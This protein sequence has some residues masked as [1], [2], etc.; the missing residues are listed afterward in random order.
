MRVYKYLFTLLS[1]VVV[2]ACADDKSDSAMSVES[3]TIEID[4]VGG[5]K[6]LKVDIADNWIVSTDNA[7]ITVSPANGA[8]AALRSKAKRNGRRL[9]RLR[10]ASSCSHR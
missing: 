6:S 7:W 9:S 3:S 1:V 8:N 4:A 5:V 10:R 2:V